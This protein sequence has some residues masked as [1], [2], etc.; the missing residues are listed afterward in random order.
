MINLA[1]TIFVLFASVLVFS[2]TPGLAF[3]YGGLVSAKNVVNTMVS[4][5]SICGVGHQLRL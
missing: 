4:I 5:F 2:M 1:N 3:F